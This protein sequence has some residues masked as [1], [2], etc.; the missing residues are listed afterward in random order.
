MCDPSIEHPHRCDE[1]REASD[2]PSGRV[3]RTA[4]GLR[5]EHKAQRVR[6]SI[7]GRQG[8]VKFVIPQILIWISE[9]EL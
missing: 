2:D 9:K 5:V 1:F 3:R 6:P 7:D 4:R 8:V